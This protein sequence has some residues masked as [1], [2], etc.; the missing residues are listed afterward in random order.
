MFDKTVKD[1]MISVDDYPTINGNA[2]LLDAFQVLSASQVKVKPGNQ[3]FRAILVLND[4]GKVIGKVGHLGFLR[5]MEPK[6]KEVFDFD[7]LTRASMSTSF[8]DSMLDHFNLWDYQ[9]IDVCLIAKNTKVHD[10]MQS[11]SESIV[12][13]ETIAN[14]IHKLI[15]WQTL[16][17]LVTSG[18]EI[19]G[20]IRLSDIYNAIEQYAIEN[21]QT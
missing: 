11:S 4:E 20:I 17:I 2:T 13:N 8:L 10:I 1:L 15:M 12:E 5:A 21:C 14:A 6:Y 18:K 9:Q 19:V 3:P 16:S 7:K